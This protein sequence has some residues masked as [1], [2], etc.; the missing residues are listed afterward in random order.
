MKLQHGLLVMLFA[1]SVSAQAAQPTVDSKVA[2]AAAAQT[3]TTNTNPVTGS[4]SAAIK[5]APAAKTTAA[6]P[7]VEQ[8]GFSIGSV[9][10]SAIT[11][12]VEN[13]EPSNNLQTVGSDQNQLYFFTELRD[14]SGQTA[15]HRWEHDGKVMAEVEFNVKGPRWRVWSSKTFVPGWAGDWKV[16]V[17]N[18]AGDVISTKTFSYETAS[19]QQAAEPAT[20]AAP[21]GMSTPQ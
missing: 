8:A 18:G 7:M 2:P 4:P 10:R 13:R 3:G 15:K 17:V 5:P 1:A 12:A 16:S 20:P 19:A 9:V 6:E 14:M 11:T 21:S